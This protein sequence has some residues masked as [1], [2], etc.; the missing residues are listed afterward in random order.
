MSQE[1]IA[2]KLKLLTAALGIAGLFVFGF[3]GKRLYMA[4]FALSED[5]RW[6]PSL[7][8]EKIHISASHLIPFLM[9]IVTMVLCYMVLYRFYCVCSEIGKD[10]SFSRE[11]VRNFARMKVLLLILGGIWAGYAVA[12][13]ILNRGGYLALVYRAAIF[14]V[15]FFAIAAFADALSK[16]IERAYEI[17]EENDLTI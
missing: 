11:N 6:D 3:I 13:L 15:I 4:Y 7:V 14:A 10:N 12:F 5:G 8:P 1:R 9:I 16:L 2:K 17:R